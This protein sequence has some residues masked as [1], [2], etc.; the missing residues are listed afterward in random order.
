MS[1]LGFSVMLNMLMGSE[2]FDM[3]QVQ[4]KRIAS[5]VVDDDALSLTFVDGSRVRIT[6]EG[7]SCCEHRY[8]TLDAGELPYFVGSTLLGIEVRDVAEEQVD[9]YGETHEVQFLHVTTSK[10]VIV[11]AT[12]NEHNGYYGG[13]SLTAKYEADGVRED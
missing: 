3:T 11:V 4:G 2:A 5:I 12:H 1:Q 6:D 7:Q 13:F 9:D 8:M 10:G